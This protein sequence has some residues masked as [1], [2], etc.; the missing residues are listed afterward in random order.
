MTAQSSTPTSTSA[1]VYPSR[2]SYEKNAAYVAESKILSQ[3]IAGDSTPTKEELDRYREGLL[4]ADPLADAVVEM[5]K[6]L[7][8]G[9]GRKMLEQAIEHGIESVDNPPQQLVAFFK[10]LDT[11][12]DWVDEDI[13]KLGSQTSRRVGSTANWFLRNGALMGGYRFSSITKP[14]VFTG[15]L[16]GKVTS[17]RRLTETGHFWFEATRENNLTRFSEGFK[18]TVHVRMMHALSRKKVLNA[19]NW[20]TSKWG[21]PINQYDMVGT[22]IAFSALFLLGARM[23]GYHFSKEESRSVMH[24]WRYVAYLLGID[25]KL[26]PVSEQDARRI[27][28]AFFL[29]QNDQID[30]DSLE[31]AEA[32]RDLPLI[33]AKTPV[34]VLKAKILI[35]MNA[36]FTRF[37]VGDHGSNA[38][39]VPKTTFFKIL[40]ILLPMTVIPKEIIRK[41]IPGGNRIAT[42]FGGKQQAKEVKN[43]LDALRTIV[44]EVKAKSEFQAV[45]TLTAKAG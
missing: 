43:G 3:L 2:F 42:W 18:I 39:N 21:I 31:L 22:N 11:V 4:T 6:E 17:V 24:L 28:Y 23:V 45:D 34:E 8:P 26:T 5:Y 25:E 35:Q 38:L 32:L 36:G 10:Q 7:A 40:P 16:G 30:E 44:G 1:D 33:T 29:Y 19:K 41:I 20:D 13:M 12:P 27:I 15:S 9:Q 14:L 37:Y